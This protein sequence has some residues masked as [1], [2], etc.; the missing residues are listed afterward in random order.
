MVE[1]AVISKLIFDLMVEL[2]TLGAP[3]VLPGK[4]F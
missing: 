1:V 4:A 2:P 3:L